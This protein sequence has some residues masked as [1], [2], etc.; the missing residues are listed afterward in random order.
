MRTQIDDNLEETVARLVAHLWF[1]CKLESGTDRVIC[2]SQ[3]QAEDNRTALYAWIR[4][5]LQHC[6]NLTLPEI[7][8]RLEH[9]LKARLKLWDQHPERT[10]NARR[11]KQPLTARN[12]D[13]SDLP[14]PF[15]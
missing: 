12:K 3:G 10:R 4:K 11:A 8:T 5:E 13:L 1:A 6:A 9:R 14:Y 7:R 15:R 2:L